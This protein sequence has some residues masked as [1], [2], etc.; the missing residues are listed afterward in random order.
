MPLWH[1]YHPPGA[2]T[3]QQKQQFADDITGLYT[4]VGLPRFY[5][6]ALFHGVDQASFYIGGKPSKTAVRIV[7]EH[8]ALKME[9]PARRIQNREAIARLVAPHTTERDLYCEFHID[10]T[11]RDLWMMDGIAP[12]PFKSEA[13]KLWVQENRPIPY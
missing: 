10:E 9:D 1:I 3:P 5:V 8:I 6:V 13:E 2:Y 4:R 12:P 7:V 11:P